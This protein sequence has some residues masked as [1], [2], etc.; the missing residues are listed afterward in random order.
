MFHTHGGFDPRYDSESYSRT[1]E[2]TADAADLP[3][4]LAT[5]DMFIKRYVPKPHLPR[6][7]NVDTIGRTGECKCN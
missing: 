1:D 2:N 5:P 3:S 4:Y 6:Q 7:G